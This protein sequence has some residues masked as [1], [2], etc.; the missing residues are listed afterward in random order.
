MNFLDW[1]VVAVSAVSAAL[2][3]VGWRLRCAER[4]NAEICE[5]GEDE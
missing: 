3:G 5:W 2:I 4:A 1:T